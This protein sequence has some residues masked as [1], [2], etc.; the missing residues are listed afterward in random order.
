MKTSVKLV[1]LALLT[2]LGMGG[3]TKIVLA[4]S[5][6]VV[7]ADPAT[8]QAPKEASDG[9]GET[10]DDSQNP[11]ESA[12]LQAM[13]EVTPEQAQSSAEATM[14]KPSD[15]VEI[16]NDDGSLVYAVSFGQQDVKVDAGTG[17][18]LYTDNQ[19]GQEQANNPRSSIQ[20]SGT[21]RGDG[22]GETNDDG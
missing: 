11:Q 7:A 4:Q 6:V 8:S 20:L 1:R 14:G 15:K 2:A 18:V 22:D 12:R 13:A 17:A 19:H 21:D 5:P 10:N 3:L 16:E 9:D